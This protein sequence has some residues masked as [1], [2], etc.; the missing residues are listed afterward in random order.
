VAG[1]VAGDACFSNQLFDD[2][3]DGLGGQVGW[4][5]PS[6]PVQRAEKRSFGALKDLDPSFDRPYRQVSG[7][8]P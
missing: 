2:Q 8:R 6:V 3:G 4:V 7:A 5:D 1:V